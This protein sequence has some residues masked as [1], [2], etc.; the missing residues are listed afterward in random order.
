[1]RRREGVQAVLNTVRGWAYVGVGGARMERSQLDTCNGASVRGWRYYAHSTYASENRRPAYSSR[2]RVSE[3]VSAMH[4][5]AW[6]WR[7]HAQGEG[8][9]EAEL[10][11]DCR[12]Y[13]QE[14]KLTSAQGGP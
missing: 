14:A 3:R 9:P 2:R 6:A 1:M 13:V 5:G 4:A 7:P 8:N 11:R 12:M 10:I